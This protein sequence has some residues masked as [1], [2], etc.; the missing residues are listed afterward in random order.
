MTYQDPL[1]KRTLGTSLALR[2][3]HD[4]NDIDLVK[5]LPVLD[6]LRAEARERDTGRG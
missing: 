5:L 4:A 2:A 1:L 6:Q 3:T